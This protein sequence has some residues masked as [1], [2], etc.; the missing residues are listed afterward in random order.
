MDG[1]TSTKN[2]RALGYV[3]PIIGA[4]GNGLESDVRYFKQ[5]GADEVLIKPID[6]KEFERVMAHKRYVRE[7]RGV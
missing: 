7:E 4:T 5:M 1:P 2:I 3:L 6:L